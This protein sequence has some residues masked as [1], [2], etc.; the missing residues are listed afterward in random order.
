M[1]LVKNQIL[2]GYTH[3]EVSPRQAHGLLYDQQLMSSLR[4]ARDVLI[5][6]NLEVTIRP[7]TID[8]GALVHTGGAV[9]RSFQFRLPDGNFTIITFSN[10]KLEQFVVGSEDTFT[11]ITTLWDNTDIAAMDGKQHENDMLF[12]TPAKEPL[13][14]QLTPGTPDTYALTTVQLGKAG[15]ND[16]AWHATSDWPWTV[17]WMIGRFILLSP[18]KYYGSNIATSA[19]GVLDWDVVFKT[20]D[21]ES[22]VKAGSAFEFDAADDLD[23]GFH[24][25]RGGSMAFAGSPAGVWMLSNYDNALDATNPNI[26]NYSSVGTYN[27][28]AADLDG[29]MAYFANDGVTMKTF[30][31]TPEGP[32]NVE[33]NPYAKHFFEDSKPVR[34]VYQR[35]PDTILWIL[36]E[37]GTL[38]SFSG[39]QKRQAWCLHTTEGT[40][41]D[42]W[43]GKDN[44][45][46]YLYMDI[47]RVTDRRVERFGEVDPFL[48][49]YFADGLITEES[50]GEVPIESMAAGGSG[51][52]VYTITGHGFSGG[53]VVR[54]VGLD[55]QYAY[56][57][58]IDADSFS[59]ERPNLTLIE[60]SLG[61][62]FSIDPAVLDYTAAHLANKTLDV[63]GDGYYSSITADGSGKVTFEIP[64]SDFA[65][66]LPYTGYIQPRSFIN[67]HG[68]YK[69]TVNKIQPRLY[70]TKG[71]VYGQNGLT[72]EKDLIPTDGDD[73][74]G[75]VELSIPGGMD[76]DCTFYVGGR[77]SPFTMLSCIVELSVGEN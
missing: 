19:N 68:A 72:D 65:I 1:S 30:A 15:T 55:D 76:H 11:P 59:L 6:R 61:Y 4:A 67:I 3:G 20:V 27:V 52:G 35:T 42:I 16:P 24:W 28:P 8:Q 5:S 23:S 63:Y 71:I 47:D 25:I 2:S 18:R 21:G 40:I 22:I 62:A 46:E 74:S 45:N 58:Y 53:E 56:I 73:F 49:S 60:A 36:R 26:K 50:T 69:A 14:F 34:M 75:S 32:L 41:K 64:A 37:N 38:V 54:T 17:S 48:N 13:L 31:V 57:V 10:L 44:T 66:G 70:R 29:V 7:P 33:M 77:R 39:D 51:E 9:T 43:L 12:T